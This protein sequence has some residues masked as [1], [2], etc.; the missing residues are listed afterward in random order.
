LNL[1]I[2]ISII[3]IMERLEQ[4][5][6]QEFPQQ[7][8]RFL[9]AGKE[10]GVDT[11]RMRLVNGIRVESVVW[12]GFFPNAFGQN[13][14]CVAAGELN[15]EIPLLPSFVKGL[16]QNIELPS[17]AKPKDLV[18]G[19]NGSDLNPPLQ[20]PISQLPTIGILFLPKKI[21]GSEEAAF[22]RISSELDP[23]D[24]LRTIRESLNNS[25]VN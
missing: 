23:K 6:R 7:M 5:Y 17:D 16:L 12:V 14:P 19:L 13:F 21:I 3:P 11:Y 8:E 25:S 18:F 24:S 1:V 10:Q 4:R 15:G 2:E 20:N 9:A 22:L